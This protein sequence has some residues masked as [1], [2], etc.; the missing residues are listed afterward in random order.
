MGS[1]A[2]S[3]PQGHQFHDE[4]GLL[5]FCMEFHTF[6]SCLLGFSLVFPV[7]THL[8]KNMWVCGLT[9]LKGPY[10]C[11]CVARCPKMNWCSMHGVLLLCSQ[12]SWGRFWINHNPDQDKAVTWNDW[13]TEWIHT[14]LQ[15]FIRNL[16]KKFWCNHC[17]AFI[18]SVNSIKIMYRAPCA[19]SV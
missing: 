4:L 9:T 7:S 13:L 11:E 8:S 1:V 17:L 10:V 6:S 16:M 19:T 3:H 18:L 5:S 14:Y 12:C 15:I 2:G